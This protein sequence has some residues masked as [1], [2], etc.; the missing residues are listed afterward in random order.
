MADNSSKAQL[1]ALKEEV[2][3]STFDF[4]QIYAMLIL[5]WRW[6]LIS[7]VICVG[8]ALIYLRFLTPVYQSTAKL[9]IKDEGNRGGSSLQN[10]TNLGDRKSVV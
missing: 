10:S 4:S 3:K 2:E 9:L 7:F 5:N 6:F 1:E 8:S